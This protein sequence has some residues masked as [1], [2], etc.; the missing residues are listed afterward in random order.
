MAL[1]RLTT[2]SSG[3]VL[4]ASALNAEF[5][6]LINSSLS[7]ISPLTGTLDANNNQVSGMRLENRSTNPTLGNTGR[8]WFRTDLNAVV[9]DSGSAALYV[10]SMQ[11]LAKGSLIVAQAAT[12]YGLLSAGTNGLALVADSA[13]TLGVKW[14]TVG[15]PLQSQVFN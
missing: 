8:I 13:Q 2:W 6:Q 3:Q 1:S 14:A 10:P 5:D 9:S 12:G 11:S 7:L 4:T 15:D